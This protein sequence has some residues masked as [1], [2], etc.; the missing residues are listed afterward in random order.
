MEWV[1]SMGGG[2][3][4]EVDG[5]I[6]INNPNAAAAFTRVKSWVSGPKP[7]S[8]IATLSYQ[9]GEVLAAWQAGL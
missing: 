6:S 5:T 3:V 4:V 9:E 2:T 1:H 7:I 8:P